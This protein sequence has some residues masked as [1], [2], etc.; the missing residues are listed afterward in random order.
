MSNNTNIFLALGYP[1]QRLWG[2]ILE[3]KKNWVI[4]TTKDLTQRIIMWLV[5]NQLDIDNNIWNKPSIWDLLVFNWYLK[6]EDL[7][8]RLQN[9]NIKLRLWELLYLSGYLTIEKLNKSLFDF[10]RLKE[11]YYLKSHKKLEM[12]FGKFL[13]NKW[14]ISEDI[15][16]K[17]LQDNWIL[18]AKNILNSNS[19]IVVDY[20]DMSLDE[21]EK[22]FWIKKVWELSSETIVNA[23]DDIWS[24][25]EW[26]DSKLHRKL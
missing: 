24:K 9:L 5:R 1:S 23:D 22:L 2:I 11:F 13:I 4:N 18:P 7:I 17:V 8:N 14:Y 21:R 20:I 19:W 16:S 25:F 10:Y 26:K 12:A 15:L 6:R 3:D